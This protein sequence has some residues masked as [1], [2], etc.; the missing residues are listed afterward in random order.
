MSGI[1]S[2]PDDELEKMAQAAAPAKVPALS[3][4]TD[5]QLNA[6]AGVDPEEAKAAKPAPAKKKSGF[7]AAMEGLARS[8][9]YW[10]SPGASI[11][12][13]GNGGAPLTMEEATRQEV[14][15]AT[16]LLSEEDTK[17]MADTGEVGTRVLAS[18]LPGTGVSLKEGAEALVRGPNPK[19]RL[20]GVTEAAAETARGL[21]TPTN[22]QLMAYGGYAPKPV[23][24]L[25]EGYF[26]SE[27][28]KGLGT[29]VGEAMYP[30]P[31][32][33]PAQRA[34]PWASAFF[35]AAGFGLMGTGMNRTAREIFATKNSAEVMPALNEA[36]DRAQSDKEAA[37]L[38][39]VLDRYQNWQASLTR[40][41][42]DIE[43]VPTSQLEAMENEGGPVIADESSQEIYRQKVNDELRAAEPAPE[44][45]RLPEEPAPAEQADQPSPADEKLPQILPRIAEIDKALLTARGGSRRKLLEERLRL[46]VEAEHPGSIQAQL[47]YENELERQAETPDINAI[48]KKVVNRNGI[49][50]AEN[51]TM[52]GEVDILRESGVNWKRFHAKGATLADLGSAIS[53]ELELQGI[54]PEQVPEAQYHGEGIEDWFGEGNTS[55]LIQRAFSEGERPPLEVPRVEIGMR[56]VGPRPPGID[57]IPEADLQI[58]SGGVEPPNDLG[59]QPPEQGQPGFIT[60]IKNAVVDREREQRGLQPLYSQAGMTN[61]ELWDAALARID[62]DPNSPVR[63]TDELSEKNRPVDAVE[64]AVLLHERVTRKIA[65]EDAA[66]EMEQAYASGDAARIAE[67]RTRVGAALDDFQQI[68]QVLRQSGTTASRAL[69]SRKLMVDDQYSLAEMT[70]AKKAVNGGELTPDQEI[71]IA[72]TSRAIEEQEKNLQDFLL[73]R[74]AGLADQQGKTGINELI[75]DTLRSQPG[76]DSGKMPRTPKDLLDGN[77][78]VISNF[79]QKLARMFVERGVVERE[80]LIDAVHGIL[81]TLLP[82]LERRETQDAISGYGQFKPLTQDEV[83]VRLRDLKGQMQ[84]IAKLQDMEHGQA[85]LKTGVERRIPSDVERELIKRVNEAKK[86][87]N[88]SAKDPAAAL[89]SALQSAET[90]IG[91]EIA[92]I[93]RQLRNE[94]PFDAT[95]TAP[96][97][98]AAIEALKVKLGKLREV[99]DAMRDRLQPGK[100]SEPDI[101]RQEELAKELAQRKVALQKQIDNFERQIKARVK[102]VKN[103]SNLVYDEEGQK[104][105]ARRDEL[106]DQF[107]EVFKKP[108]L[109]DAERL[110]AWKDRTEKQIASWEERLKAGDFKP[111]P[112]KLPVSLDAKARAMQ[113][114]LDSVKQSWQEG[115]IRDQM[116]NRTPGERWMDW[117]VNWARGVKLSSLK[118]FPKLTEAG[119]IRIVT[120]PIMRTAAQP[121]RAIPGLAG[122]APY[123]MGASIRAESKAFSAFVRSGPDAWRKLTQGRTDIDV[124]AG[125]LR[126]DKEMLGFIA[127]AHGMV[128]EPVRQAV[129]ARSLELRAQAAMRAG[130]DVHDPTVQQAII[131]SAAADANRGI[132]MGDNMATKYLV[133]LPLRALENSGITGAKTLSKTLQVL[134][135]IVNVPTNIAIWSARLHPAIGFSEAGGRLLYAMKRGEL[136]EFCAKLSEEDARAI[137]HSFSAGMIGTVL[138]AYA[139][140]HPEDFGGQFD[141]PGHDKKGLKA[142]EINVF[143]HTMPAW[144]NHAPELNF[145]NTTASA[146]RIYQRDFKKTGS[147]MDSA[148]DALAFSMLAPVKN[149]PFVEPYLRMF[150]THQTAG[151]IVGA[152]VRDSIFPQALSNLMGWLD[153]VQRAP[154]TFSQQLSM[155]IP[156][157]RQTVPAKKARPVSW[158]NPR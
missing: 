69:S 97:T 158:Q 24:L 132:L 144:M 67:A 91:N 82:E 89:K 26:A 36:I 115:L 141:E 12:V 150:D 7:D 95:R 76:E 98:S 128:K 73:D 14:E 29:H 152:M 117:A 133:R 45:E 39:Q 59:Y 46:G 120:D 103:P 99:R 92:D 113:V 96:P 1:K 157:A 40:P 9:G 149:L 121:L 119:L 56:R 2:I 83:S 58:M 33:T 135:P 23:A 80:A 116:R 18:L 10:G 148:A 5:E 107:N 145:L 50:N 62:Q 49:T 68:D 6:L 42:V 156:G 85:P 108:G 147:Q 111:R 104:L 53:Q 55:Q 41:E 38:T 78:Y 31:N 124:G 47:D 105:I 11:E 71:E 101:L 27:M 106:R 37:Q 88:F 137:V 109:T 13:G 57:A 100:S 66:K 64:H 51:Y 131:A 127:N 125:R 20:H 151:A 79:A 4:M 155:P 72:N 134:M 118:V 54:R 154:K 86:A 114:Q 138:A 35:E 17:K 146:S 130:L 48:V 32:A 126:R 93:E 110:Q 143:G 8:G 70:L 43:K 65:F 52:K 60:G 3:D 129:Y 122:R 94:A 25:G 15:R 84:Q 61:P 90:R 19:S 136:A 81:K 34:K 153:P 44:A 102:D 16:P 140:T 74:Q 22:L 112:R 28:G 77:P 63:L 75:K 123:E 139:W 30:D 142:G 87:G 21:T